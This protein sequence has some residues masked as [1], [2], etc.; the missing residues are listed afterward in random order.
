[1]L[2]LRAGPRLTAMRRLE[3]CASQA[4]AHDDLL[5]TKEIAHGSS[6]A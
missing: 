1:M 3:L 4:E 5:G 6:R 2:A